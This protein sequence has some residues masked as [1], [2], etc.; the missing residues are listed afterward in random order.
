M[1]ET[2]RE[3]S[4]VAEKALDAAKK[5]GATEAS[6]SVRQSRFFSVSIEDGEVD[7]L[8]ESADR[9]LS[10]RLFVEGR[11]LA[12]ST[13]DLRPDALRDFVSRGVEA[14][15][16]LDEEPDR[17]LPDEE[18]LADP[19]SVDLQN[20]DPAIDEVSKE[21]K[22]DMAVQAE[23]SARA[24]DP[25]IFHAQARFYESR[26]ER[27]LHNSAGFEGHQLS[28]GF[29]VSAS[30]FARDT[31]HKQRVQWDYRNGVKLSMLDDPA[32]V[33]V[34]AANRALRARG[35]RQVPSGK[36]DL[37]LENRVG[38]W[39]LRLLLVPING[40]ILYQERS[41]LRDKL[42]EQ[43]ATPL[44]TI[45]DEPKL[46]RA[47]GSRLFDGEGI[48]SRPRA[49]VEQGVLKNFFLDTFHARKL[50]IAPTSGSSS[51]LVLAPGEN[52]PDQII[53]GVKKGIWVTGM[54]GGGSNSLTGD[55][56]SGI[57]GFLIENGEVGH[58]V[59]EINVAG[60][61]QDLLMSIAEVGNDPF[62][63]SRRRVPTLKL[64]DLAVSGT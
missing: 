61:T 27:V 52:S 32:A 35:S 18:L 55:F 31:E 2:K 19:P 38:D 58:P 21:H 60:R 11:Y 12:A 36:Y 28:T 42:G 29:Y 8:E 56:S 3:L 13:S 14:A 40:R 45:R 49:I 1:S 22:M 26:R 33:G 59:G 7:S 37:V 15:R 9:G 39:L 20:Y 10:L 34:E 64:P 23:A 54:Q 5:A 4:R 46:K 48:A 30:A 53:K 17:R 16:F 62:L 44:L 25:A 43:V 63:H 6:A 24:V 57:G 41:F 51:N 50:G 47:L